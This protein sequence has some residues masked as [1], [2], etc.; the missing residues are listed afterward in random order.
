MT[1][2]QGGAEAE[3]VE[4]H[5]DLWILRIPDT[6]NTSPCLEHRMFWEGRLAV[7]CVGWLGLFSVESIKAACAKLNK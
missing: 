2:V 4:A 3:A 1:E 5:G 7:S 6:F